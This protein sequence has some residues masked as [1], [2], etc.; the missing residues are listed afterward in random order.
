MKKVRKS[1]AKKNWRGM[2]A[3]QVFTYSKRVASNMKKNV[4]VFTDPKVEYPDQILHVNTA[5]ELYNIHIHGTPQDT[6][7]YEAAMEIVYD[8]LDLQADYVDI[9]ADG[10]PDIIFL[11]GFDS[12]K[13]DY[14]L[15]KKEVVYTTSGK[16]KIKVVLKAIEEATGYC[17]QYQYADSKDGYWILADC[18]RRAEFTYTGLNSYTSCLLRHAAIIENT[19]TE[20]SQPFEMGVL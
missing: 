12:T 5:E 17:W 7:N 18:T 2:K 13:I 6:V 19:L 4:I 1:Y 10:N 11:S 14:K 3:P 16:G 9:V 15:Y 8:D 20:F